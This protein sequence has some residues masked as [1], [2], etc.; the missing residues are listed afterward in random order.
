MEA[1]FNQNKQLL[2]III[3]SLLVF[4]IGYYTGNSEIVIATDNQ[5]VITI[6]P[7]EQIRAINSQ[8]YYYEVFG[9][10]VNPGLYKSDE[11]MLVMQAVENA[12]GFSSNA[13]TAYVYK[14]MKLAVTIKPAEKI[15]IPAIGEDVPFLDNNAEDSKK[16]IN[17]NTAS[18]DILDSIPGIGEVTAKKIIAARPFNNCQEVDNIPTLNKTVKQNL[19]EVCEL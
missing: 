14:N 18:I 6:C 15:Y 11:E 5:D 19:L 3:L 1:I 9:A 8:G 7:T 13:D 12:G 10:V 2:L 16:A 4:T 17:I